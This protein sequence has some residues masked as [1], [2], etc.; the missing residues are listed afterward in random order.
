MKRL[1]FLCALVFA[2]PVS[3]ASTEINERAALKKDGLLMVIST[4][5][6]VVISGWSQNEVEVT[7]TLGKEAEKLIFDVDGD[8][9]LVKVEQRKEKRDYNSWRSNSDGTK[10]MIRAPHSAHLKVKT[11]SADVNIDGIRGMQRVRTVSGDLHS[12]VE[13]EEAELRTVSG[14]LHVMG[15]GKIKEVSL[16]SVS[17]E[18]E[19]SGLAGEVW[20]ESVSGDIEL[21]ARDVKEARLK[22]VSGDI[23]GSLDLLK[24]AEVHMESVSGDIEVSLP[25]N[26]A[27]EYELTSFSGDIGRILGIEPTRKS[28]YSPGSELMY[29]HGKSKARVR[30]NSMSGDID[31]EMDL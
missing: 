10:L 9:I 26:Y 25:K 24:D 5:G 18:I 2:V 7:G 14:D 22:T 4:E 8:E 23:E 30:A 13:G 28:K 3:L 11:V 16:Y 12:R 1:I 27:A 17:G 19:G 29:T 20:A 21:A 6:E 31:I 15:N